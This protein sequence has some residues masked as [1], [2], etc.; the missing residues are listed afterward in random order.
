MISRSYGHSLS[1]VGFD[2]IGRISDFG[3]TRILQLRSGRAT[4]F[5]LSTVGATPDYAASE[6]LL[7]GAEKTSKSDMFSLGVTII[8][9][10]TGQLS[11]PQPLLYI[12]NGE[13]RTRP[14]TE[15]RKRDIDAIRQPEV[16][17]LV[18]DLLH[19]DP[20]RRSVAEDVLARLIA[21]H[22]TVRESTAT[23]TATTSSC[24]R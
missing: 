3:Q 8:H 15:R 12:V 1:L 16:R 10:V 17:R 14:E 2:G 6:T 24:P 7:D 22:R 18:E 23:A 11:R 9:I 20:A 5:T 4:P 19:D 13:R 21:I